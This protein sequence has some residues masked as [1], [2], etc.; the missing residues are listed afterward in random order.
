MR[1]EVVALSEVAA[2]S[3]GRLAL[4]KDVK[5]CCFE[6]ARTLCGNRMGTG[7]K[8]RGV[9]SAGYQDVS[10]ASSSSVIKEV[11]NETDKSWPRNP[12]P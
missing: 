6:M 3:E 5:P 9:S 10:A 1:R 4:V 2:E 11:R 12:E 7:C 8:G